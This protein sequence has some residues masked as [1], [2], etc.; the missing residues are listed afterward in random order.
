MRTSIAAAGG[1][2]STLG[3]VIAGNRQYEYQWTSSIH[4]VS[5]E[6]WNELTSNEP[7]PILEHEWLSCLE[8]S[9]SVSPQ[10]GW[11]PRHLLVYLPPDSGADGDSRRLVAAAPLYLRDESMGEF[12]FDF[13]WARVASEIGAPYYPKLVGMSPMTPCPAYR[14]L[15]HPDFEAERDSIQRYA[16]D[17]IDAFCRAEHIPTAQFNFT[18]L[19]FHLAAEAKGFRRW[20]HQGFVWRNHGYHSFDDYLAGFTKNQRRN[21]RRE[22]ASMDTQ[23]IVIRALTGQDIPEGMFRSMWKYYKATNDQFGPWAAR[24]LTPQFFDLADERARHA[25]LF[26]AAYEGQDAADGA[27]E[28]IALSMLVWKDRTMLGRYWGAEGFVKDLHF[29]LCY[30]SPIE[31]A[32]EHG[33]EFF[34]PGM[35][36]AHKLR[37]GFEAVKNYSVHRFFDPRMDYILENNIER[38]NAYEEEMISQMNSARPVK[39]EPKS[40]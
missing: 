11:Q 8:D 40:D 9:G 4:D 12:V 6:L 32:I 38:I 13:A 24:F 22:R 27:D 18:H 30:Y 26:F 1:A 28:P 37:R 2:V 33:I 20:E 5:A 36:S 16:L 35:G 17:R 34:D 29:N 3:S 21:I 39:D 15:V 7:V 23:G 10:E 14:I 25:V 31:W 19:D